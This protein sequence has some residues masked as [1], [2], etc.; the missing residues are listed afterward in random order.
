MFWVRMKAPGVTVR[1]IH[2]MDGSA[3]FNEVFFDDVRLS[4]AQRVG[5]VGGGWKAA[6]HAL[7]N[8]RLVADQSGMGWQDFLALARSID[9]APRTPAIDDRA[10][11]AKLAD[12]YVL[13]E[14]LR[15]TRNRSLTALSRGQTPGPENSIIKLVRAGQMLDMANAA[16]ELL[17]PFG[18]IDDPDVSKATQVAHGSLFWAPGL[19]IAG[20]TDEVLRNIIA[21]RVLGL[22]GEVRLDKDVPF[23]EIPTGR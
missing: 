17:G 23:N 19:R 22:P 18:A 2:E 6:I 15:H 4:D 3:G 16:V 12:W 5:P 11:R 13:Q 1:P 10:I 8:E 7:M 20:G 21:E 9:V 14:G